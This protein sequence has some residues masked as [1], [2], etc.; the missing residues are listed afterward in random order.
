[1]DKRRKRTAQFKAKVALEAL[2]G[3]LTL[4]ELAS[5]YGVHP[6]QIAPAISASPPWKRP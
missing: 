4:P 1:M 3:E 6:T 2:F 5:T